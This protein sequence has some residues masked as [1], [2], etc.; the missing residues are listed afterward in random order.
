MLDTQSF[1]WDSPS[2]SRAQSNQVP[3]HKNHSAKV[4]KRRTTSKTKQD[5]ADLLKNFQ[6]ILDFRH[7]TEEPILGVLG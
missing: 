2:K 7:S 4:E 6:W 3:V 1:Q 5:L